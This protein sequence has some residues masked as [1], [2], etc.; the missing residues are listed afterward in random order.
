MDEI[1]RRHGF[2]WLAELSERDAERLLPRP[3][4]SRQYA[5]GETVFEPSVDPPNVY[6]LDTGLVRIYRLSAKGAEAT[7]GYVRPGE[8]FGEL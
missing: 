7:L 3:S 5:R 8:L 6:L 2:D 4:S 1:W